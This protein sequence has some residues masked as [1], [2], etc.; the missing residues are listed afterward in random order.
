MGDSIATGVHHFRQECLSYAKSGITSQGWLKRYGTDNLVA[1]TIVISLGAND[2]EGSNTYRKLLHIR[3]KIRGQKIVWIA[4]N[5]QIMPHLYQDVNTIAGMF[6]DT[7]IWT[8]KYS[9]DKI[10]PSRAGYKEL[11]EKTK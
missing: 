6:G 11:A 10:H 3:E 4:P 8:E 7:V 2:W 5:Q 1:N 9:K